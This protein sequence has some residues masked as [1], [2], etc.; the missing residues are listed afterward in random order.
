MR[1]FR[2]DKHTHMGRVQLWRTGIIPGVLIDFNV[3]RNHY[4]QGL[5]CTGIRNGGRILHLLK[6]CYY[7]DHVSDQMAAVQELP[8]AKK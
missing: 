4:D 8:W 5:R 3:M 2:G 6:K 7:F 1:C